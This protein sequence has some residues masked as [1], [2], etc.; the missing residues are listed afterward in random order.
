MALGLDLYEQDDLVSFAQERSNPAGYN[1]RIH[2]TV[3][4]LITE[5]TELD[6]SR[7]TQDLYDVIERLQHYRDYDPEKQTDLGQVA[8]WVRS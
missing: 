7:R 3:A 2:P 1:D 4:R 6:R 8:G 5:M